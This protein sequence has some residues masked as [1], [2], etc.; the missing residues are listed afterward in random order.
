M[1]LRWKEGGFVPGAGEEREASLAA[2]LVGVGI[3]E[4]RDREAR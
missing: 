3:L 1:A 4:R 2:E